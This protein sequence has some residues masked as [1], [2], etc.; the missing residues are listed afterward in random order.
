MK[1]TRTLLLLT[2]VAMFFSSCQKDSVTLRLRF[3]GFTN[4]TKVYI[5]DNRFPQWIPE[6]DTINVNGLE[7]PV[8]VGNSSQEN[9]VTVATSSNYLAVYPNSICQSISGNEATLLIPQHQEYRTAQVGNEVVQVVK[10]PMSA[11]VTSGNTLVF[12]NGGALLAINVVN[13]YGQDPLMIDE[14]TVSASDMALW[15]DATL[16]FSQTTPAYTVS[17]QVEGHNAVTLSSINQV[18]E[19][20]GHKV[21]YIYVPETPSVVDNRYTIL[22]SAHSS[23]HEGTFTRSQT[24]A[25]AGTIAR[26][27]MAAFDFGLG[28]N[29]VT[30]V[31]ARSEY[32]NGTIR[33]GKFSV[34]SR[35]QVYFSA[36]NLQYYCSSDSPQWRFAPAQ[37]HICG[38][39]NNA[40]GANT[41]N[42][43]D[44]F[45]WGTSGNLT[46]NYPYQ[47][48]F[49]SSNYGDGQNDI[50]SC[51]TDWGEY[52]SGHGILSYNSLPSYK[53]SDYPWRTLTQTQWLYLLNPTNANNRRRIN[54]VGGIGHTFSIVSVNGTVGLLIYPDDFTQGGPTTLNPVP[55]VNLSDYLGCAFLPYAG[56]R[57]QAASGSD[58]GPSD[59]YYPGTSS[60]AWYWTS[61]V[62][63]N[64]QGT[65]TSNKAYALQINHQGSSNSASSTVISASSQFRYKGLPVRLVCNVPPSTK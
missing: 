3:K 13:N 30:P 44:L 46:N 54:G 10:A 9:T 7:Y 48:A 18:L 42:W 50:A 63:Y 20:G 59:T 14:I 12:E 57:D 28:D 17:S 31:W 56:Y 23:D 35:W 16:D 49:A 27:D 65:A 33:G 53:S 15:G 47:T 8:S 11:K 21:F 26:G 25:N 38:A 55:T 60:T 52:L 5:D 64:S 39:D 43:I 36:G 19:A 58:E 29:G 40:P 34:S 6:V 32:P 2:L 41:G 4:D 62:A 37:I 24:T 45:G 22:V 61:S 51:L 1:T